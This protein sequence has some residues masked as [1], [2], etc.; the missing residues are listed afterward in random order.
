VSLALMAGRLPEGRVSALSD[1]RGSRRGGARRSDRHGTRQSPAQTSGSLRS[2]LDPAPS[3][4]DSRRA[5]TTYDPGARRRRRLGRVAL[6]GLVV[7]LLAI[8]GGGAAFAWYR[9]IDR[10][11]HP[12]TGSLA[13]LQS[14]LSVAP[15]PGQ[16]FYMVIMGVD[17]RATDT[18]L[19]HSDTLMV[20]YVDAARKRITTMSIPRDTRVTIPG[21]GVQ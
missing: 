16:P 18:S 2:P 3:R 19:D 6:V 20:A 5:W 13:N 9:T 10:N 8:I 14:A 4:S 21:H 7:A 11:I 17:T 1:D 12:V 15:P